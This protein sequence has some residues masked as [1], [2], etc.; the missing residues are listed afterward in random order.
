MIRSNFSPLEQILV[1]DSAAKFFVRREGSAGGVGI[2]P[3]A[4]SVNGCGNS[5]WLTASLADL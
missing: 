3:R 1:E 4:C 5:R 2:Y